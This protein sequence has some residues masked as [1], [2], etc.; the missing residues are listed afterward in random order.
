MRGQLSRL[1]GSWAP[2]TCELDLV[3]KRHFRRSA[4]KMTF[5][6]AAQSQVIAHLYWRDSSRP[7]YT[8]Q[9]LRSISSTYNIFSQQTDPNS[10]DAASALAALLSACKHAKCLSSTISAELDHACKSLLICQN[11]VCTP[12]NRLHPAF[13]TLLGRSDDPGILNATGA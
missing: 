4:R 6:N 12:R 1:C 7:L 13:L 2:A 5:H 8:R 9:P 10:R 3:V 11:I